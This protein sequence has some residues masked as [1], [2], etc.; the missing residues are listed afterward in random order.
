MI[1]STLCHTA[2]LEC[3]REAEQIEISCICTDS[4]AVSAG[5]LFV[6]LRG[7]K[8]DGHAYLAQAASGGACAAVIAEDYAGEIPQGLVVMR[9]PDTRVAVACLYDAWYGKPSSKMKFV[10]ITGTNGKTSVA[11]LLYELL[12]YAHVPA[13]LV[14]TVKCEGPAGEFAKDTE[15]C[16]NMTT[17]DPAVLYPMLASMAEQGVEIVVM[18]VT[19][20]A[21]AQQR[22]AP[23]HFDLGIF[24][25]ITRDHLDFHGSMEAYFAA[26][27]KMLAQC[28]RVL[29]N[30][31]D[32]QLATLRTQSPCRL[33][34]CSARNAQ[35]DFYPEEVSMTF[36]GMSYKL[37]S[38][39]AHVRIA[40]GMSGQ[41]AIINSVE[42]IA[43]A[44]LLGVKAQKIK[45]G[46]ALMPPVPGRMERVPLR[47]E[48]GFSVLIDYAHTPD[49]LES[50]LRSVHRL[51]LRAQRIVLVFG[52]GGDRDKGKR[53]QM[54]QIASRMAD[55]FVIT[56]DNCR[57]EPVMDIISDILKGVD[58]RA[59]YR[60]IADRRSAIRHV[61]AH[62][63]ANDVI[64]LVGKGHETYE[65]NQ[66][67]RLAFDERAIV[68]EAVAAYWKSAL[69]DIEQGE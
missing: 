10:G 9:V 19:S 8:A 28:E 39:N 12:R 15:S 1:L 14:G 41:F 59:H 16:A 24:T 25:N 38:A 54:G 68:R 51:K 67:T 43:A 6:C 61:I 2:G 55:Y 57:T 49:A 4:S 5:H 42:A 34:T 18:E 63:R 58:R 7:T 52:C 48:L 64:L 11:W 22:C 69:T 29:I 23:L 3:P 21:L 56:S 46:M 13:G 33:Y 53:A 27:K 37:V 62:A 30:L 35:A 66:N 17:P 47:P 44:L 20:H 31:D 36:S 32:A 50:L 40:C 60:V 26:K 65:I 45:D